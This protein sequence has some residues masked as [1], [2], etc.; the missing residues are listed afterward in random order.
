MCAFSGA[1]PVR[2]WQWPAAQRDC[3]TVRR[4]SIKI[5]PIMP[6]MPI[7]MIWL[8]VTI[9]NTV[10]VAIVVAIMR[11]I[12]K[13]YRKAYLATT[14]ATTTMLPRHCQWVVQR[15][16]AATAFFV[17]FIYYYFFNIIFSSF[18]LQ[19]IAGLSNAIGHPCHNWLN[20]W[21]KLRIFFLLLCKHF[22]R[23]DVP[24]PNNPPKC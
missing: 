18:C 12:K 3:V 6:I 4:V 20:V 15:C 16:S 11:H 7:I 19:H 24:A 2:L 10:I 9:A 22:H 5:M 8:Q 17:L 13:A 14:T 21:K 23:T 1:G